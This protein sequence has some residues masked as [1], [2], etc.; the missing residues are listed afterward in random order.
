MNI[1]LAISYRE[2]VLT[3]IKEI[4]MKD[5][6]CRTLKTLVEEE[7]KKRNRKVKILPLNI[8]VWRSLKW[9]AVMNCTDSQS[10]LLVSTIY[11]TK[12]KASVQTKFFP[13]MKGYGI[14]RRQRI[15]SHNPSGFCR[16][17]WPHMQWM[18][19]TSQPQ[20]PGS[21]FWESSCYFIEASCL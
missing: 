10:L 21:V 19:P 18:Y 15:V 16:C 14:V 12:N 6:I 20:S 13:Q 3:A 2:N 4:V 7:E 1:L 11:P 17:A 9:E 5:C 8:T